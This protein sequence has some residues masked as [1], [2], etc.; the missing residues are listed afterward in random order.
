MRLGLAAY[1]LIAGGETSTPFTLMRRVDLRQLAPGI[2]L[3]RLTGA[4]V[5]H[6]VVPTTRADPGRPR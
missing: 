5:Y 6:D 4:Y 2:D 3:S 1:D